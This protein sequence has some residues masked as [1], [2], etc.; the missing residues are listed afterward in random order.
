MYKSDLT[1]EEILKRIVEE[2]E[3]YL[4]NAENYKN[5]HNKFM[6]DLYK[7]KA[8]CIDTLMKILEITEE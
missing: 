4:F 2:R 6:E 5:E 8:E 7:N 1:K 3:M